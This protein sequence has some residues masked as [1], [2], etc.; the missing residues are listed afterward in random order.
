[1]SLSVSNSLSTSGLQAQAQPSPERQAFVDLAKSLRT[2]DLSAARQAYAD[3]I[4]N[5]PEGASFKPGSSFAEVGKAL[6]KGDVP[7]AQ[8][9]FQ[10]MLRGASGKG[11]GTAPQAST[12]VVSST[13]G[14]AGSLLNAVA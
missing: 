11:G 1:M 5:A 2:G 7:A 6:L 10:T 4:R 12:A 3:V 13:G 9:A 14:T 8:E